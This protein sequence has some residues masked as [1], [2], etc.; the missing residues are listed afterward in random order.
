MLRNAAK[1]RIRRMIQE[2]RKR[3]DLSVPAWVAAEWNKGT[4][5][6]EQMAGVLLEVNGNKDWCDLWCLFSTDCVVNMFLCSQTCFSQNDFLVELEKIVTQKRSIRLVK[7]GGWYSEAEMR[8][9]LQW[10][11]SLASTW[12]MHSFTYH[13][14]TP[15]VPVKLKHRTMELRQRIN[16]AKSFCSDP[17][18]IN[19]YTRRD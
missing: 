3:S 8:N 4:A 14:S 18:R 16:G 13:V 19:S 5:S 12:S 17:S 6:K 7:D 2:K 10:S 1:A 9:E 15:H 11:Q